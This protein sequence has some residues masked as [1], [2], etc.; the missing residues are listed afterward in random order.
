MESFWQDA[1]VRAGLNTVRVYTGPNVQES[2]RPP[3]WSFGYTPEQADE[4]LALVLEGRKTATASA[5]RDYGPDDELPAVGS[6]SI[7]TDGS[8]KPR[9]LIEVTQVDV[10]PFAEVSAEHAEAEGEGDQSLDYWRR[11]HRAFFEA[12]GEEPVSDEMPI[13]LERFTVLVAASGTH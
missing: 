13:V 9:A 1:V 6:L 8:G 2:L 5:L 11:E 10:V 3:A 12:T 7:I 4:L